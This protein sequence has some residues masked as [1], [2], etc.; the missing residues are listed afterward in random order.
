MSPSRR[1]RLLAGLAFALLGVLPAWRAAAQEPGNGE[2]PAAP[3]TA[4]TGAPR[5]FFYH[6]DQ[7]YGS[8]GQFSPLNVMATHGLSTLAWSSA[9]RHL[10]RIDWGN[11][12]SNVWDAV[13]RPAAA[14][15]R[16]GG[17]GH[18]LHQELGPVTWHV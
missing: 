16:S 5:Y 18:W 7:P 1:T 4:S 15:E 14:V 17:C 3:A 13:A 10:L 6:P 2:G 8:A 11:G 9:E 12:W